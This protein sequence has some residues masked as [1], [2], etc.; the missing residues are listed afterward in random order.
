MHQVKKFDRNSNNYKGKPSNPNSQRSN[1]N[2]QWD[3]DSS[4]SVN[5]IFDLNLALLHTKKFEFILDSG[6]NGS[7][8]AERELFTSLDES[9]QSKFNYKVGSGDIFRTLGK[10]R[11]SIFKNCAFSPQMPF[12]LISES[13]LEDL[14]F[15]ISTSD[16]LK[17]LRHSN[18]NFEIK[19][20]RSVDKLY[21][22]Q[23]E[24]FNDCLH[25]LSD[26]DDENKDWVV[27]NRSRRTKSNRIDN[28]SCFIPKI[29]NN[30]NISTISEPKSEESNF[31]STQLSI[32]NSSE[33]L[34][35]LWHARTYHL[36]GKGFINSV[37]NGKIKVSGLENIDHCK[38]FCETC[39]LGKQK[40]KPYAKKSLNRSN[41]KL[42]RVFSD[43]K[44][45]FRTKS[46]GGKRYY[47]SFIDDFTRRSWIYCISNKNESLNVLKSFIDEIAIPKNFN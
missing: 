10:G 35:R 26:Q 21:R 39:A 42:G 2:I 11:V 8:C 12:N 36:S 22:V 17:I 32:S 24:V 14:G 47:M 33:D 20:P 40:K 15:T 4:A 41:E 25:L 19:I 43:L 7:F 28:G 1:F 31:P 6:A 9:E 29:I 38:H 44:G 16:G 30:S 46:L 13:D 5:L 23:L 45:P 3:S 37:K 34:H 18:L 27:V